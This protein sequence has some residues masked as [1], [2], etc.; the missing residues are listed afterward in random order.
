MKRMFTVLLALGFTISAAHAQSTTAGANVTSQGQAQAQ[1]GASGVVF[2]PVTNGGG[3]DYKVASAIVSPLVAGFN[4]CTG[5]DVAALQLGTWG[6]SLGGTKADDPCNLRSDSGQI[7]QM[8]DHAAAYARLCQNED[9]QY[10]IN[11]TGGITYRRADGAEVHRPCPM[12]KADWIA[13]G[14]P[15]LDPVTGQPYTD[16]PI[17]VTPAKTDP[18]VA[19]IEQRAA[20][21]AKHDQIVSPM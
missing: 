9:N 4:T 6:V 21:I 11:V 15:L 3:V 10:A 2:A 5:S 1:G 8:G 19:I 12:A 16:P 7:F 14:R 17:I 20:Q 18:N 13:A